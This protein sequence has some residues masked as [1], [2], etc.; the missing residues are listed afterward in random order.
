MHACCV[1][2]V[3]MVSGATWLLALELVSQ[4]GSLVC[5]V[6]LLARELVAKALQIPHA[7]A[8]ADVVEIDHPLQILNVFFV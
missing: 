2:E 8:W 7:E 1:L 5:Y 6:S 3:Q 4:N